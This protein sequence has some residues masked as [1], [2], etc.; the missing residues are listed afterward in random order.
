MG[1]V[2]RRRIVLLRVVLFS[3]LLLMVS[4]VAHAEKRVALVIGNSAYRPQG[5]LTNPRNDATGCS[6]CTEGSRLSGHRRV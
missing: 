1:V 6:R 4:P 2:L 5:E 3:F